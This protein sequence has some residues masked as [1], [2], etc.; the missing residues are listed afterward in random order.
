MGRLWSLALRGG[1]VMFAVFRQLA[2]MMFFA[3]T[4]YR[5]QSAPEGGDAA[6]NGKTHAGA[7]PNGESSGRATKSSH[8]A[9]QT[10]F[11]RRN[12]GLKISLKK[13]EKSLDGFGRVP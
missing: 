5:E 13:S 4:N 3:R 1:A 11:S 7:H 8:R 9:A 12:C 10:E 6:A 2:R